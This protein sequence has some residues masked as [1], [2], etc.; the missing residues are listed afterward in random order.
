MS[1]KKKR[2]KVFFIRGG[3]NAKVG[4]QEVPGLTGKF[5]HGGQ[6]E[7]GQ[8]PTEICQENTLIIANTFFQQQRDDFTHEHHQMV[9]SQ[10]R[11][12]IFI[13]AEDGETLYSQEKKKKNQELTA[14][15]VMNSLSKIQ[16]SIKESRENY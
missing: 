13:A 11:F 4:S 1:L 3:W 7:P 8:R 12:I 2:K 14:A 5:G 16:I 6:N 9:N 15:Q 10:T